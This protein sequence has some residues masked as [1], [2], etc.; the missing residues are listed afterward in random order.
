MQMPLNL[1][2]M[3][4]YFLAFGVLS[5]YLISCN[6]PSKYFDPEFVKLNMTLNDTAETISLG[7]TLKFKLTIP[8]TLNGVSRRVPVNT[9]QQGFYTFTFYQIDTIAKRGIR[10]GGNC[11]YVTE[12]TTDGFQVN[13]SKS[14]KP[15]TATLNLIPPSKGVYN[16]QVTPQ[17][18]T[19]RVNNSY[20]A[21]LRVNVDVTDKHWSM[22]ISYFGSGWIN[23]LPQVD[24]SG[25]AFYAFKVN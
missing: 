13:V 1:I 15:F 24:A 18:G 23:D 3:I 9:L 20:E 22:F 6:P 11:I 14:T 8:D 5:L 25:Y 2:S 16:F 19:I 7:D 21:G 12:G 4:K 17:P 10:L